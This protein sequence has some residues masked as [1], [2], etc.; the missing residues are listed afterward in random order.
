LVFKKVEDFWDDEKCVEGEATY[1]KWLSFRDGVVES[2]P[3]HPMS[4]FKD[5]VPRF[6]MM[7][8]VN[9]QSLESRGPGIGMEQH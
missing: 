7:G 2:S 5:P 6:H 4:E 9:C 8:A 3:T 1:R